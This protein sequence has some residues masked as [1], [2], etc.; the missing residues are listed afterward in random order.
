MRSSMQRRHAGSSRAFPLRPISAA[1]GFPGL[2]AYVGLTRIANAAPGETIFVSA[3]SG[4]V[5]SIVAQIAKLNGL[6]V[7]ASADTSDKATWL[8]SEIGADAVINY[9]ETSDLTEALA[10]AAPDGIDIYF[11]NVGGDHLEAALALANDHARFVL[12]GMI[13]GYNSGGA[14]GPR[15]IFQ[16]IEKRIRL[17]GLI[18]SDH[19]DLIPE[20][21]RKMSAWIKERKIHLR[22]TV[23]DGLENAPDAFVG[24]FK[25]ANTGKM[26]VR[27]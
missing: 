8:R 5:G 14:A 20:F 18:V 4:A 6:R 1:L 24:L 25:G 21:D 26:L 15:N 16:A 7:I 22:E 11:D 2:T 13:T 19:V 23:V 17:Q 10:A 3:A 12:C 9:R 27:L